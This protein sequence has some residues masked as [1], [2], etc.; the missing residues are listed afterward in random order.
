MREDNSVEMEAAHQN[1]PQ[2]YVSIFMD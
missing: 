2:I 1:V